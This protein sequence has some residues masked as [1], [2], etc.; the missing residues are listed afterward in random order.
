MLVVCCVFSHAD[1]DDHAGCRGNM[2]RAL[3]QW[4]H[5]VASC[6]ATVALHRAMFITLH[7]PGGMVTK[8]AIEL[9][10]CVY[11]I[12]NSA[13]RKKLF[14][15]H[16]YNLAESLRPRPLP[17]TGPHCPCA[18]LGKTKKLVP[19]KG[20]KAHHGGNDCVVCCVIIYILIPT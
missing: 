16:F 3:A 5:L 4:Q 20:R 17:I 2:V 12:D 19:L 6:E 10:T 8:I 18:G 15:P 11:I 9:V 14:L 7:R 13:A 1:D